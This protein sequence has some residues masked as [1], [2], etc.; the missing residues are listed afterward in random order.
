MNVEAQYDL[1]CAAD[2]LAD[3]LSKIEPLKRD[4]A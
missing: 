3:A 1:E 2:E 4:A